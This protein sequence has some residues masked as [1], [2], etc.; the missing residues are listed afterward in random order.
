MYISNPCY[1]NQQVSS[2]STLFRNRNCTAERHPGIAKLQGTTPALH[3]V[4]PYYKIRLGTLKTHPMLRPKRFYSERCSVP[5]R[6]NKSSLRFACRTETYFRARTR[7]KCT[8]LRTICAR[9]SASLS[10]LEGRCHPP[11]SSIGQHLQPHP[12]VAIQGSFTCCNV[13]LCTTHFR[14]FCAIRKVLL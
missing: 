5:Q 2:A 14:E 1:K 13:P 9:N 10:C 11:P 4:T 6:T 7:T 3:G 8:R 12:I